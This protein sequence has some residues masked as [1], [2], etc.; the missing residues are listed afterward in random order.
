MKN[1]GTTGLEKKVSNFRQFLLVS[2]SN[3]G[4]KD[5]YDN[6]KAMCRKA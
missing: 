4:S 5:N 3:F 6:M 2:K 1:G